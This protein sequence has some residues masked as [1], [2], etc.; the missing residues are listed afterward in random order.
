MDSKIYDIVLFHY[1]CQDGLASAWIANH[2]HKL[3]NQLIELYPIQYGTPLDLKRLGGGG[4]PNA[5]GFST[6]TN[7]TV[8]FS[9]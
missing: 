4:H 7:P 3:Q 8:L 6:K 9:E 2:Y 1:P 5:S